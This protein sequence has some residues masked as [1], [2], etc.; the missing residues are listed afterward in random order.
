MK[1][2]VSSVANTLA[3]L[4]MPNHKNT[5]KF[6][7]SMPEFRQATEEIVFTAYKVGYRD[8][9]HNAKRDEVKE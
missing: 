4:E 6:L 8:G 7:L 1:D 3:R 2:K 9:K 5:L